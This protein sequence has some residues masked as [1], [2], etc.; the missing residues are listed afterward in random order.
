V[1]ELSTEDPSNPEVN[2]KYEEQYVAGLLA[3]S[4]WL[5][6]IKARLEQQIAQLPA[7][8]PP[9]AQPQAAVQPKTLQAE[10]TVIPELTYKGLDLRGDVDLSLPYPYFG[11]DAHVGR[12]SFGGEAGV[13]TPVLF[14][15]LELKAGYGMT[16]EQ[17]II[18]GDLID[19][20]NMQ[21][22]SVA[23]KVKMVKG[24][25]LKINS[26]TLWQYRNGFEKA[27]SGVGLDMNYVSSRF[28]AE[29]GGRLVFNKKTPSYPSLEQCAYIEGGPKGFGPKWVNKMGIRLSYYGRERF[30]AGIVLN[31]I[32]SNGT[33]GVK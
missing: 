24:M 32:I 20:R 14:D 12:F 13:R 10:F 33:E 25:S 8:Q 1:S 28:Y 11:I 22:A 9:V 18:D 15:R 3:L 30:G 31:G 26:S 7:V 27:A 5:K 6:G 4:K 2:T 23:A 16:R 17:N 29:A 19:P 21:T